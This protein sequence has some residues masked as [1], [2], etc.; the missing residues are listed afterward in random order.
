M[1]NFN[2]ALRRFSWSLITFFL[3]SN[4]TYFFNVF[5]SP[6]PEATPFSRSY[7]VYKSYTV[8]V[9]EVQPHFGPFPCLQVEVH[10]VPTSLGLVLARRLKRRL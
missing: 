2:L 7:S 9:L 6:N 1:A 5:K 10:W 8:M 4:Y 3:S